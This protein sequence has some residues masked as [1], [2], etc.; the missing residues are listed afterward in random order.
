MRLT[1]RTSSHLV[2]GRSPLLRSCVGIALVSIVST[3]CGQEQHLP[4]D[5][6][7]SVGRWDVAAVEWDGRPVDGQFLSLLQVEYRGDGSWTV[8]FKGLA[9]AEGTSVNHPDKAPKTF[10]MATLGSEGIAPSRY[11]GI[12]RME[13]DVRVLCMVPERARRPAEFSAPRR[14]GRMLVT[15]RRAHGAAGR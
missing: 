5:R 10:E 2:V 6:A 15:L 9:V 13:G 14:S 12:Y 4:D 7:I 11:A 8:F 1:P 3:A